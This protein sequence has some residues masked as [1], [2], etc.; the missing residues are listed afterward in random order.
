M[1]K[2]NFEVHKNTQIEYTMNQLDKEKWVEDTLES[3]KDSQR[4]QA[5]DGLFE[6]AMRRV[7]YGRA[8]MVRMPPAQVWSAAACAIVLIVANLFMCLDFSHAG[9]KALNSKEMFT[10]EYFG[11]SDAPQF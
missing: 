9:K 10:K 1:N 8:R 6:N 7:A 3:L 11:A 4:A 2:T 5:P